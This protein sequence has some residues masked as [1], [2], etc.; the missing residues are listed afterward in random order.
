MCVCIYIYNVTSR[1]PPPLLSISTPSFNATLH[2]APDGSGCVRE[3]A[4][5]N[6]QVWRRVM[7]HTWSEWSLVTAAVICQVRLSSEDRSL[8]R[9]C[10]LVSSWV[11]EGI[12]EGA[13]SCRTHCP[14][15]N[16]TR[17]TTDG[18]GCRAVYPQ[19]AAWV[20]RTKQDEA[21]KGSRCPLAPRT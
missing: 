3:E 19:E 15:E 11:Q 5:W 1:L 14:D 16:S 18:P 9:A 2:Q 13:V 20:R 17:Y 10:P 21:A 8:T 4:R 12:V 6:S 7:R